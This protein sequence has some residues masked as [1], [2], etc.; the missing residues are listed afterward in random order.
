VTTIETRPELANA[1]PERPENH[2]AIVIDGVEYGIPRLDGLDLDEEQILWDYCSTAIPDFMPAHPE[3]PPE[4]LEAIALL[5]A[6]RTRNPAFK[7]A[8]VIIAYRRVHPELDV[9]SISELVGKINAF[10]AELALYG[11]ATEAAAEDAAKPDP[12]IST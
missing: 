5:H 8:L 4:I 7:R 2:S 1:E 12:P 9:E 11:K 3:S 10:D 6:T